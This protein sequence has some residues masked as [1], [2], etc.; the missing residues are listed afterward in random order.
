MMMF[1]LLIIHNSQEVDK[2]LY[3]IKRKS[4]NSVN[5]ILVIYMMHKGYLNIDHVYLYSYV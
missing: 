2:K 5:I 3:L 1:V 4:Y